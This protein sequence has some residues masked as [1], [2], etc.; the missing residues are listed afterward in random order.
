MDYA[1]FQQLL[2]ADEPPDLPPALRALW[3]Q[4]RGDW[5]GAHATVQEAG[6]ADA[7]RVHAHLHRVEGDAGNAAYWYRRAGR[8][9]EKGSL[10]AEWEA[11]ARE[12][13]ERDFRA[14]GEST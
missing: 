13:L 11:L 10:E 3:Q 1:E 8:M 2:A 9:P 4:G 14:E 12:F 5:H 7:A 6:G